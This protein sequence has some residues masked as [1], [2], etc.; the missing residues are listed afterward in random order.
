MNTSHEYW[1]K[2]PFLPPLPTPSCLCAER[3]VGWQTP[4]LTNNLLHLKI[5]TSQAMW[6]RFKSL[7]LASISRWSFHLRVQSLMFTTVPHLMRP[8]T[9][10]L[11]T[12]NRWWE[13]NTQLSIGLWI[14]TFRNPIRHQSGGN[15][16]KLADFIAPDSIVNLILNKCR[17]LT[18]VVLSWRTSWVGLQY[19]SHFSN[20]P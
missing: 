14:S 17:P 6:G 3:G 2:R 19:W 18:S 16:K 8:G 10:F 1:S 12:T 13:V 9:G 4:T 15:I 20:N 5:H 11:F 7:T